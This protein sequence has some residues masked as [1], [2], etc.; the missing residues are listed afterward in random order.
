MDS[1]YILFIGKFLYYFLFNITF[2]I[3]FFWGVAGIINICRDYKILKKD[4]S[5]ELFWG[6]IISGII[7][8]CLFFGSFIILFQKKYTLFFIPFFYGLFISYILFWGF[9]KKK[10]KKY[11]ISGIIMLIESLLVCFFYIY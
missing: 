5:K 4:S 6:A 2:S 8:I 10:K 11:I 7:G 3:F 1:T 9:W